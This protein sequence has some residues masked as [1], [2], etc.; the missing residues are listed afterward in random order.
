MYN[1]S[2]GT[3]KGGECKPFCTAKDLKPCKCSKVEDAC[4]VC[5][6]GLEPNSICTPYINNDTG[7]TMDILD[8]R[9]CQGE[10]QQGTCVQVLRAT[11]LLIE[12]DFQLS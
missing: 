12:I 4:K 7:T 8:G 5:C 10:G 3:C 6:K 9:S 1:I 2:R 11:S